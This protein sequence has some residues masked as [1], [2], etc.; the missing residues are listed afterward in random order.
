VHPTEDLGPGDLAG[1]FALGEER[2]I[3]RGLETE[4]LNECE[5]GKKKSVK[6]DKEASRIQPVTLLSPRTK[7]VPLLG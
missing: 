2:G 5:I 6:K 4:Y 1:I 7:S 3:F